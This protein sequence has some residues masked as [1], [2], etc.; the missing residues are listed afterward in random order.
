MEIVRYSKG[1]SLRP[2]F[3]HGKREEIPVVAMPDRVQRVHKASVE[4]ASSTWKGKHTKTKLS[5]GNTPAKD[6]AAQQCQTAFYRKGY[7]LV[8]EGYCV[9]LVKFENQAYSRSLIAKI[10]SDEGLEFFH[11]ANED[12]DLRERVY[13]LLGMRHDSTAA[14]YRRQYLSES[15]PWSDSK[16]KAVQKDSVRCRNRN[17]QNRRKN[18]AKKQAIEKYGVLDLK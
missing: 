10:R 5:W 18:A 9:Y 8:A 1:D 11:A 15:T 7:T 14:A 13:Q 12:P 4:P 2:S 6:G 17:K 16:K 3:S